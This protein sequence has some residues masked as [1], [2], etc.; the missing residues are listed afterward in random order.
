[1][2]LNKPGKLDSDEMAVI[3]QHPLIGVKVL[4]DI[5][6]EPEVIE[7]VR[8]HHERFDGKGYPD[9]RSSSEFPLSVRILC[10]ADAYD[11][12]TSD[13][14]YR[15]GMPYETVRKILLECKDTQFDPEVVD[16]FIKS[17]D[18]EQ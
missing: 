6:L 14:P 15:N 17:L 5:D 3:Q 18:G 1:M 2:I 13:R 10:V 16:V 9:S 8:S 4:E 12:M 7:M 11:A